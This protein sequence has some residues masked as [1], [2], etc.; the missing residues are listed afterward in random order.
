MWLLDNE[1][2]FAVERTWIR[3]GRGAEFWLVVVRASFEI[4]PDGQQVL[5]EAQTEVKRAPEFG[6]DP[7]RSGMLHDTDFVLCKSGTDV[8]LEGTAVAPTETP[9]DKM[10]VR[11]K[12]ANVDKSLRVIGNRRIEPAL[13]GQR[14]TDP[15]PFT[16][17]PLRWENT[18]GGWDEADTAWEPSNPVGRGFSVHAATLDGTLAPNVEYMDAPYRGCASGKPA[19]TGPVAPH[20]QPRV[21]YAGTY[22]ARWSETRDPLPPEDFD[23]RYYHAAPADQQTRKPLMGYEEVTISGFN[24]QGALRFVIPRLSFD[25]ITKFKGS[26]DARQSPSLHTLL[27]CPN[28]RRFELVY[29]TALEVPPSKEDKLVGSTA[30]LRKRVGTPDSNLRTGVWTAET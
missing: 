1:T 4:T 18:Y 15:E 9:V 8:L 27:L 16:E 7:M 23:L 12:V 30:R 6:G 26:S 20:W 10:A 22:D 29:H 14:L 11:F 2:P 21:G 5:A 19:G 13:M 17:M 24:G 3:D 28:Q 25:I